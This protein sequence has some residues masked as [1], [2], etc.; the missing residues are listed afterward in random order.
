MVM[1]FEG[2]GLKPVNV[3]R[4]VSWPCLRVDGRGWGVQAHKC[5]GGEFKHTN[6]GGSN[7]NLAGM[8]GGG[9]MVRISIHVHEADLWQGWDRDNLSLKRGFDHI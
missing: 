1:I 8:L 9:S 6:R 7:M 5:G 2:G 3:C 4:T